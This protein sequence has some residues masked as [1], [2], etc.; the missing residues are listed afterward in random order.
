MV[1]FQGLKIATTCRYIK[2][3]LGNAIEVIEDFERSAFDIKFP[4]GTKSSDIVHNKIEV[5]ADKELVE[6]LRYIKIE[7]P[8]INL[9]G[10][11]VKKLTQVDCLF[12][13]FIVADIG[14]YVVK[15]EEDK[16]S[17]LI[18]EK[19]SKSIQRYIEK[20]NDNPYFEVIDYSELKELANYS[21]IYL[22]EKPV[23]IESS[24]K[25]LHN[26]QAKYSKYILSMEKVQ[27]S[28]LEHVTEILK[29]YGVDL[30][31]LPVSEG[32]RTV[33]HVVYR[34]VELGA[35]MSRKT[36]DEESL[37]Y[38]VPHKAIWEFEL[39]TPNIIVLNDFKTK[40][41]NLDLLTNLTE[42]Y[43]KDDLGR[44]WLSSVWWGAAHNEFEQDFAQDSRGY[45][46][47]RFMFQA[48]LNYWVVYDE[49]LS[50]IKDMMLGLLVYDT[51]KQEPDYQ[52][53]LMK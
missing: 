4:E 21:N 31:K 9:N 3:T 7:T 45:N 50:R 15:Y 20:W 39:S 35:Q 17:I 25:F 29:G 28:F 44:N 52:T 19:F 33:N 5:L 22:T 42:F 16:C 34:I 23:A 37:R 46:A 41:Q 13:Q 49:T 51:V 10:L 24:N 43:T 27:E 18:P 30:I 8:E 26:T 47:F 14:Q 53:S 12:T 48:E 40:Y 32:I 6:T 38:A 2:F 1:V 11:R 36:M